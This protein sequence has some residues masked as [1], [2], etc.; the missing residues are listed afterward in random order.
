MLRG[1]LH[2][3][4]HGPETL[5]LK[6]RLSKGELYDVLAERADRAGLD[7]RR[8][9]LVQGLAGEILEIGAGTGR[10]FEYYAS[11]ARV[12]ALDP[13]PAFTEQSMAAASR[14]AAKVRLMP[15]A[16]ESLPFEAATF[17]G[18]VAALTLCSVRSVPAVLAELKRVLRP[19]AELR[20]L[21]HVRS[22]RPVPGFLMWAFNWLW[23]LLNGDGCNMHRRPLQA[24]R[25]AGFE[26]VEVERFQV[27]SAGWPAFPLRRIRAVVRQDPLDA[28]PRRG[29]GASHR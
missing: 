5:R 12:T 10:M 25:A 23:R 6:S 1:L 29:E 16:A 21:E 9:E 19:G 27:Y 22:E 13:D 2:F 15:G 7:R 11:G 28:S 17:D 18:A 26:V 20:L 8:R 3:L 24:L 14:S 4:R